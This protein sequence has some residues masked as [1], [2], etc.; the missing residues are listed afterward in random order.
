MGD[1]GKIKPRKTPIVHRSS[2]IVHRPSSIVGPQGGCSGVARTVKHELSAARTLLLWLPVWL[3]LAATLVGMAAAYQVTRDYTV[4]MGTPQ[5]EAY[6]RN[7]HPRLNDGGRAYRWSDVYG[8]VLFPG[9]GG[10]RPFT[11]SLEL[12]PGRRAAVTAFVNGDKLFEQRL[13]P[14]WQTVTLHIDGSHPAA[15]G[16]RDTVVELRA[17]EYRAPD[18]PSE[19]K[20]VKVST[21]HLELAAGTGFVVPSYATLAYL[22]AA[23]LLVY[24]LTGRSMVGFAAP[25][26]ARLWALLAGIATGIAVCVSLVLSHVAISAAAMHLVITLLSVLA[27]LVVCEKLFLAR[28]RV[29]AAQGRVLALCVALAFGIRYVGMALPQSVIIDM[30]WHMKWLG[31]LLSGDWQSLYFPGGL[32]SVPKEWGLNL[33]IPKS[34]LFYFADAPLGFLPFDLETS[35]KWLICLLDSTLVI[36]AFWFVLRLGAPRWAA[37]A[38]AASYAF[39]PL[40]FRALAYGILPTVLAQWLA[41]AAVA[42]LVAAWERRW[43]FEWPVAILILALALLAF[44]TVA[45]FLTLVLL[46]WWLAS[47]WSRGQATGEARSWRVPLALAAA[48]VLSLWAYYGLYVSPVIA[49][50][51]ALLAPKAGAATVR[52][53][54]GLPELLGWTAD[55]VVSLLPAILAVVGV[56]LMLARKRPRNASADRTLKLLVIWLAIAP[57]FMLANLRVDMIGKHLFFTMLPVAVASGPA[58]WQLARRRGWVAMLAGLAFAAIAWQGV[59]FWIDR[60]VRASS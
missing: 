33:L 15:L 14:G 26:K 9:L 60:L 58:L 21:V 5:D 37:V 12:D 10:S 13:E 42:F 46:A 27:I 17:P 18:Q 11:V 47:G 45:L 8:Y 1:R 25:P 4:Y 40:A 3:V 31:T 41:V 35:T 24:L 2:S 19:A 59:I 28:A 34:P 57:L 52:W 54:G 44:P 49:S 48:W 56:A 32:S 22:L 50:A 30:P 43:R 55:Y 39:M 36:A 16:S 53:P 29:S 6:V 23:T 38:S 20:G 7:F 51:S